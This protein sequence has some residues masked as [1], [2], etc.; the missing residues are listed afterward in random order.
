MSSS[1]Y[2][3]DLLHFL[4]FP[5][6]IEYLSF[7][8]FNGLPVVIQPRYHLVIYSVQSRDTTLSSQVANWSHFYKLLKKLQ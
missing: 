8:F 7:V 5:F 1:L 6:S 3:L 2:E 4:C